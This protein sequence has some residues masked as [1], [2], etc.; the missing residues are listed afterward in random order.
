MGVLNATK[1]SKE[2]GHE[3]RRSRKTGKIPGI[4]YGKNI[5][6]VMFEL[7]EYDLTREVI[8]NGEHGIVDI[9]IEG[10]RYRTI[11]KNLQR[12]SMEHNLSHIDLEVISK[13]K[14]IQAEIPVVFEGENLILRKGGIVQKEKTNIKVQCS[15]DNI[16]R[17]I[18]LNL[19][20]LEIGDKYRVSDVEFSK[21]IS[22]LEDP[23]AI[24]ASITYV[25]KIVQEKKEKNEI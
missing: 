8:K 12:T 7:S 15:S 5:E 20:D 18:N 6:N 3:A 14:L 4:L 10:E 17:S 13:D 21:D 25:N 22:Y 9:D 16:P 11:I 1:R 24:L 19:A 23:N 2:K